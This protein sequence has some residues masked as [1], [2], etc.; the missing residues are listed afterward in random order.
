M[1]TMAKFTDAGVEVL[2]ETGGWR[3]PHDAEW[4]DVGGGNFVSF[5]A[6]GYWTGWWH[7][8]GGGVLVALFSIGIMA[9]V[10]S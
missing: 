4:T 8:L 1:I 3:S 2:D 5:N 9:W 7:G 6:E 10:A